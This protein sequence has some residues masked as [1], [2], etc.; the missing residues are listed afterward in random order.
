MRALFLWDVAAALRERLSARLSADDV[1]LLFV[2]EPSPER[3]RAL[4]PEADVLVGWRY[5]A[6]LLD[7]ATKC[8]LCINPGAG[9]QHLVPLFRGREAAPALVNGH[10]NARLTAV[11][12]LA[13]LLA[14]T[15][16]V[17]LHDR[18]MREGR[19]RTHVS[20]A[21]YESLALEGRTVGLLGY[22]HVGRAL[23]EL[24][25]GFRLDV[26]ALRTRWDEAPADVTPHTELGP[27]LDAV[28]TLVVAVPHTERTEGL[29]GAE[30]LARLGP[31]AVLVQ[32]SRGKVIDED[33]LFDALGDGTLA[34]AGLDVWYEYAPT[35]DDDGRRFPYRRPFHELDNVVLSPHR[36][37]SPFS[38]LERWQDVIENLRRASVGAPPINLVDLSRGY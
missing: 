21:A 13:L 31:D 37:A 7:A 19:W 18:H 17:A 32:V 10:G 1:E 5:D 2:D 6:A 25:S 3:L 35:P 24:L 15:N 27:F 34:V 8:R 12:A 16:R 23:R 9:V 14:A 30:Q 20:E 28:D 29:L 33:A 38:D 36:A 26:H 4:A 11:G 22:G